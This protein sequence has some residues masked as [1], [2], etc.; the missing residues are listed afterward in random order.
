[1]GW[2]TPVT[3]DTPWASIV[4]PA[5]NEES[6][7]GR[8]LDALAVGDMLRGVEVVVACNGCTDDTHAVAAR[9]G[10]PLGA[11]VIDVPVASKQA[12]LNAADACCRSLPRMYLDADVVASAETA[13]RVLT[14]LARGP[15]VAGRPPLEYDTAQ[16]STLVRAF[17]R[18]RARTP[19]LM[20]SL[21]GAGCYA[22]SEQG[23]SRWAQFPLHAADDLLVAN[24][25]TDTEAALIDAPPV[26]VTT[27]R[28]ARSLLTTL[29]RVYGA[30]A[31]HADLPVTAQPSGAAGSFRDLLRSNRSPSHWV[32]AGVYVGFALAA[33]AWLLAKRRRPDTWER[34]RSSR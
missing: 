33:R 21:W 18:A 17:Y 19:A 9:H 10:A 1:M 28:T 27:P 20:S 11:L 32:D 24:L 5:H 15:L 8:T 12:A 29:R 22:V 16:A 14:A 13:R 2:C 34:D 6:V 7:I 26:Q 30:R 23:R 25:F 4:I 3:E 31:V